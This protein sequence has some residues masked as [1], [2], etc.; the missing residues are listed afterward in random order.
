MKQPFVESPG[1]PGGF[2]HAGADWE[3]AL[4]IRPVGLLSGAVGG[5]MCHAGLGRPLAGGPLV[6]T[7][8]Q[9]FLTGIDAIHICVAP[10]QAALAWAEDEGS[11]IDQALARA[12]DRLTTGRLPFA[13]LSMDRTRLIGVVNVTP[14]SFSDGG[15]TLDADEAVARGLA[16]VEAGADVVEVGGESARPGADPVSADEELQ[17]VLPVVR[18]LAEHGVRLSIDTRRAAVMHAAL[19]AG[20]VTVNDITALTD[21]DDAM[22]T[23]AEHS[24]HV[25][26]MHKLGEPSTMQANPTYDHAFHEILDYLK[27]RV[28]ACENAGIPRSRIAVDPG[29]GFGKTDRHNA[30]L[31]SSA[32][33]FHG[34]GCAVAFGTSRKSFIGRLSAGEPP[35][36]RLAGSLAAVSLAVSQG[37]QFHR[38]HDVAETR[39]AAAVL[40]AVLSS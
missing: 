35:K 34:L 23:I 19:S 21:D 28:V 39:Q 11:G 26:L 25:I 17:R 32:A 13:G 7:A 38:V 24:A 5:A 33:G 15:D 8:C 27:N 3:A 20:A 40:A 36:A 37:V 22:A 14:D 10:L 12:L 6:F 18:G 29:I 16:M 1:L 30:L 2:R 4:T 9:L 31:L